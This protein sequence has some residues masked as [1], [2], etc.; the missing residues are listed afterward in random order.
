MFD[1]EIFIYESN[2]QI[3]LLIKK[4]SDNIKLIL[5]NLPVNI[6]TLIIELDKYLYDG[7]F[8]NLPSSLQKITLRVNDNVVNLKSKIK[9]GFFNFLFNIK[10]PHICAFYLSFDS[11][12]YKLEYNEDKTKIILEFSDDI[13]TI[14]YNSSV[15]I[16]GNP[17]LTFYRIVYK[18]IK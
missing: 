4:Y 2:N 17:T 5:N 15:F 12:E 10:I 9:S 14:E 11:N 1:N 3:E 8:N 6:N 16:T 13:L 18:M 7:S